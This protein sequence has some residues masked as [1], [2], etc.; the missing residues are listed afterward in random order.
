MKIVEDSPSRL[1]LKES[2][3]KVYAIGILLFIIGI[4]V[5]VIGSQAPKNGLIFVAFGVVFAIIG[6]L[7]FIFG[8]SDVVTADKQARQVIVI[9]KSLKNRN[10]QSQT[11]SFDDVLNIQLLQQYEQQMANSTNTGSGISFGNGVGVGGGQGEYII[12][13]AIQLKNGTVI[14]IAN[15]Q[16]QAGLNLG[17]SSNSLVD[18]GQKLADAIGV[19]FQQQG[20][21][22]LGQA[23]HQLKDAISGQKNIINEQPLSQPQQ[24]A[25]HIQSI[26]PQPVQS[27]PPVPPSTTPTPP[28]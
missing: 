6:L 28:N 12:N 8:K 18:K 10:G 4:V 21:E 23:F 19:P 27:S 22:S 17:V 14:T 26:T 2:A 9:F 25:P 3:L 20:S 24:V 1:V 7:I 15:E 11:C 16:K 5:A 13:L